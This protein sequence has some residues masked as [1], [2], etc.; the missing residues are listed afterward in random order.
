MML[1]IDK[2]FCKET[3]SLISV[4][5]LF[6]DAKFCNLPS[7]IGLVINQDKKLVGT[8]S[9]GDIRRAIIAGNEINS[10]IK[11]FYIPN[12]ITFEIGVSMSFILDNLPIELLKRKRNAS[13]YLSKI[14]IVNNE[15]LPVRI[16]DY[17]ELLEQRVGS[18]RHLSVIGLGYVGLTMAAVLADAG[19]LVTGVEVDDT[20]FNLLSIGKSYIHEVGLQE[21]LDQQLNRNLFISR[22][23][24]NSA[25]VFIISVGTPI[26]LGENGQMSP[27]LD[28]L[29]DASEKVG[30]VIKN[31]N[32]VILRSTVPIGA[33]R[34]IVMKKIEDISGLKCGIDFHLSF[35]PERTAE[36]KA[37]SELR[38]LPQIIGGYNKD[39]TESTAAIFRDL[40]ATII[41]VESLEAA[42]M[43]KLMNNT[44]RDY[45]FAYSNHMSQIASAY[46]INI[47]NAIKAANEGYVRDPIPMP[48]PGVGGPCLTKDPHIFASV[49][50]NNS[51]SGDLFL[52]G[53]EINES[54]HKFICE[55]VIQSLFKNGKNLN[56]CKVLLAGLAFKGNP[57]TGD[58]RNS[59][60]IEIANLLKSKIK[61]LYGYDYVA[62]EAQIS[63]YGMTP[64]N[65]NYG[66]K[67]FDA[68]L[69]LNNH[70]SFTKFNVPEML[71]QMSDKPIIF[72]GWNL[73]RWEE[74]ISVKPSTYIGLS[75]IKTTVI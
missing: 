11:S 68:I 37:L 42:E 9:E 21:L 67:D 40:T 23:I 43:V 53:R 4:M 45:V 44:Y 48:S 6:D 59:T 26:T 51:I 72:D 38:S 16:F 17:H 75:Y 55:R 66:F 46:N 7:G 47:F 35:A 60:S 27:L 8:I 41:R 31:G 28:Y 52:R 25:D 30:R 24:P 19:F 57:E 64:Y 12:P 3:D 32:L 74:V 39:S 63:E 54:M 20:R 61:N 2:L 22:E 62:D 69:F 18:H 33:C 70:M 73:F 34:N 50:V 49:S 13:K 71:R 58:L 14:I 1:N 56:E 5:R 65:I 15:N 10:E 29:I 36:G